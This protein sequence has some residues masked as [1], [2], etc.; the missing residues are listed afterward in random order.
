MTLPES[1]RALPVIHAGT[2]ED[3]FGRPWVRVAPGGGSILWTCPLCYRGMYGTVADQPVSGW[4]SPRWTVEYDAEGRLTLQPSL[5]CPGMK[6]GSCPG[7]WW[8]RAGELVPA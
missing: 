4:E 3:K 2:T 5:G 6:D 1:V 7:H 8:V